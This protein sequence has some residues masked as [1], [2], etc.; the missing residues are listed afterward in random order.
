M[1]QGSTDVASRLV[2]PAPVGK[3]GKCAQQRIRCIARQWTSKKRTRGVFHIGISST[4]FTFSVLVPFDGACL[5]AQ[6]GS[7]YAVDVSRLSIHPHLLVELTDRVW[8][9]SAWRWNRSHRDC[10][11]CGDIETPGETS[12]GSPQLLSILVIVWDS[13]CSR[14]TVKDISIAPRVLFSSKVQSSETTSWRIIYG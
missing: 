6:A 14:K 4:S 3:V 11:G 12:T 9:E 7:L 8:G 5:L 10:C 1:G 2:C 13:H